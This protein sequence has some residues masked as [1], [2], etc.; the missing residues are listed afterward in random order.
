[1]QGFW[2]SHLAAFANEL[3]AIAPPEH[4]RDGFDPR[5]AVLDIGSN[6]FHLLV[7]QLRGGGFDVIDDRREMVRLGERTFAEGVIPLQSLRRGIDALRTLQQVAR[8]LEALPIIAVGTSAIR[9]AGNGGDFIAAAARELGVGIRVLTGAEE[10]ELAYRGARHS[11]DL[12]AK[13]VALFDLG[14][15]SLEVTIGNGRW[16]S[17]ATSIPIGVLRC[18]D[19]YLSPDPPT[20]RELSVL[21][22]KVRGTLSPVAKQLWKEGF[23]SLAFLGGTARAIGELTTSMSWIAPKNGQIALSTDLLLHLE[24]QLLMLNKSERDQWISRVAPGRADTVL[25]GA[26]IFETVLALLDAN[27]AVLCTTGLREGVIDAYLETIGRAEQQI[28]IREIGA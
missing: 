22:A 8:E 24:R 21:R 13:R 28:S 7:T 10:A 26:I 9:E 4:L 20:P 23:D 5:V 14:G 1:M 3:L 16:P 18:K 12:A 19:D 6:S 27:E 17:Y 25:P 11:V 15:G 2:M